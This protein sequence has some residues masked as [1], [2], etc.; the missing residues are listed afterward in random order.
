LAVVKNWA[1]NI[2]F[3]AARTHRPSTVDELR[4]LVAGAT[5]VRALGTG[6]S[7]NRV[8]D[9]AGDLVSV[10]GLP[11][12][13]EITPDGTRA[14][15]A[16]GL[17]YGDVATALEAAG[18]ALPN[19]PSLPH[20]SLAGAVATGTHGSGDA[21]QPLS[22]AVRAVELVTA[23]GWVRTLGRGDPG[24]DGAVVALGALGIVTALTLDL[25]P[26]FAVRQ[27]VYDDLP[28]DALVANLDEV[29]SAAYSVSAFTDWRA[30]VRFHVWRKQLADAPAPPAGWLGARPADGPR[31]P[32]PGVAGE[33]STVQL[34]VPGPWHERLPHFRLGFTPSSGDELQSEF[35]VARADGADAL[36]ALAGAAEGIAPALLVA[37]VR[38]I[39]ADDQWLSPTYGRDSVGFHFTWRPEAA[40]VAPAVALV[41]SVLAPFAPRP[42][43]AKVH[44]MPA[45][46]AYP[47]AAD[48]AE[49]RRTLDPAGKFANDYVRARFP[50]DA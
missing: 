23:D 39:A 13:V 29:L 49:L 25:R 40:L 45:V 4:A 10:A 31:H 26:T 48:F 12:R 21:N 46:A 44:S 37:E 33:Q 36:A 8:A 19:L 18:R 1:G 43:W 47:R 27:Y 22:A 28:L 35:F 15:V 50:V 6:H 2:T 32:I 42:H 3:G 38:S 20:I 16:A 9:T 30:P 7:F 24:F 5:A 11:P 14:V 41:E 17:R 34:G